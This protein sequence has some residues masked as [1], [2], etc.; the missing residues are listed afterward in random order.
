MTCFVTECTDMGGLAKPSDMDNAKVQKRRQPHKENKVEKEFLPIQQQIRCATNCRVGMSF[1]LNL[2]MYNYAHCVTMR[3]DYGTSKTV[4]MI[5]KY[6][7]MRPL[8]FFMVSPQLRSIVTPFL[9]FWLFS[10]LT[11]GHFFPCSLKGDITEFFIAQRFVKCSV[12]MPFPRL[13]QSPK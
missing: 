4:P 12:A 5:R 2:K 9:C 13:L 1:T 8:S 11:C 10:L 7:Q 6:R 3:L